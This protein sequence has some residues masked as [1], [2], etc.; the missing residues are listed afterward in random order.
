MGAPD[1]SES[2]ASLDLFWCEKKYYL[3]QTPIKIIDCK[4]SKTCFSSV[5]LQKISDKVEVQK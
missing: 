3:G 5:G 2:L 4:P 1:P